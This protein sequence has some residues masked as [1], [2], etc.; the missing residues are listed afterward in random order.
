MKIALV[1]DHFLEFG[2]AERVVVALK[3]IFPDADVFTSAYNAELLHKR[4]P[5]SKSW[6]IYTSWAARI[7]FFAKLYSPL[8][9]LAPWIWESFDFSAYDVV[10]SSSGWFM[11]KGIITKKET[12]HISYVHHQP[13]YLYY[14][15][16]AVEWQKYFLVK[17]YAHFINHFLRMWDYIGSQRP[18]IL[19]ANSEE[20][21]KRIQKFY[22]RDSMVIYPPVKIPDFVNPATRKPEYFV[23][24]SRLTKTKNVD[25]I[26]KT[27][28][29]LKIPLKIIGKGR[30]E[31]YLRSLAGETVEF[32]GHVGDKEFREVYSKAKAFLSAAIDEEFG[33]APVEAMGYGVPVIAYASGGLT[34]TVKEGR[35]GFLFYELSTESFAEAI[36]TFEKLSKKDYIDM[37]EAARRQAEKYSF[38]EFQEQMK[39]L[40]L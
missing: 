32:L 33:I 27:A 20:T 23:T 40:V 12:K 6:T 9:F 24:L 2:G 37:S 8:R 34:E 22:R 4:A 11:S 25:L 31:E 29:K 21:Q 15:E 28:N 14:Y 19:I 39:K 5:S 7:P 16:T 3:K 17:V 10:I 36:E 38:K 30:D 18:D 13:R 35:N 26:I 1:H